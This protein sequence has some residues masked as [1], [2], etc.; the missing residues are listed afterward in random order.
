[1]DVS[2]VKIPHF[3]SP[4]CVTVIHMTIVHI[5]HIDLKKPQKTKIQYKY[6]HL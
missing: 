3:N 2:F 5:G 4:K 6:F 1:M